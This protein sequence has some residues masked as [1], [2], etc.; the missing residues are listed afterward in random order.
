[1]VY[2]D[3]TEKCPENIERTPQLLSDKYR[4]ALCGLS[5]SRHKVCSP[6]ALCNIPR[7][8]ENISVGSNVQAE[9]SH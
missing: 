7:D 8:M 2:Y 4:N 3:P 6:K 9:G 1:M 5:L